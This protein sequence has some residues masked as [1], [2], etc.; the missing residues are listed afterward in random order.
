MTT[1]ILH[2]NPDGSMTGRCDSRCY[3]AK[4][5]KCTCI[6]GGINHQKGQ[7]QAIKNT[8]INRHLIFEQ[9]EA[10]DLTFVRGQYELF[11][12]GKP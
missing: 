12:G 6:C 11:S 9:L 5:E 4:L 2:R 3:N 8:V 10:N 1:L 7:D